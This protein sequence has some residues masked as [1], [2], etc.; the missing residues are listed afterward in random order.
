MFKI[1]AVGI[2]MTNTRIRVVTVAVSV[3]FFN[4]FNNILYNGYNM[5]ARINPVKIVIM[6]GWN[7]LNEKYRT[8]NENANRK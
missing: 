4:F 7:I 8:I 6:K 2:T 5:Y 3:S 1:N